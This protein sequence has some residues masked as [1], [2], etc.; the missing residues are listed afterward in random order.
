MTEL[1]QKVVDFIAAEGLLSAGG[2]VL[3][4]VSGGADSTALLHTMASLKTDG[5][6]AVEIHCAHI[7]HQLRGDEAERDEDF[8]VEQCRKLKIAVIT[9]RIDVR[10]YAKA[11]KLSIET[12]ARKL[13]IE[14]LLEIAKAQNCTCIATAHQKND[15]AETILHRLSRGTG[16][17][18]L[19]GIWPVKEFTTGIRFVRPLLCVDR[20]QILEYLNQRNLK[21]CEDRT[22]LDCYYRRNFIRNR[23]LPALQKGFKADLVEQLAGLAKVS[24]GFY[25]LICRSA[26]AI[27][28]DVATS[29]E[30][31]VMLDLKTLAEQHPE[32]KIEIVRRALARLAGGERDIT[33]QHYNDILRLPENKAAQLPGDIEVRHQGQTIVFTRCPKKSI[34]AGVA[35]AV[36]L[37]APGVTEFAG[38]LIKA[39]TFEYD[40]TKFENF[41]AAKTNSVEW[42][43]LDSIKPPIVVRFRRHG[44]KF[45]PL[46]MPGE[47]KVG[48]FLTG[49]KTPQALR[50]N[51]LVIADCEKIIWLCPVRLSEQTKVTSRTK[52]VLQLKA[53]S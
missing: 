26:D 35:E 24:R 46:G 3:L 7:N 30:Q 27:W 17:R 1:E 52:K 36:E 9:Q 15:N 4:A 21:W 31:A 10:G 45:W 38:L 14:S 18:G 53:C 2:R 6:L 34:E 44:D 42:L 16:L 33:E 39:E 13:R 47:K 25:R 5:V 28:P 51:L 8:V 48:K 50:K 43:D 29:Q 49:E 11:E 32:I 41:K 20:R 19:C 37:K 12:A 22:N 23:M 40:T